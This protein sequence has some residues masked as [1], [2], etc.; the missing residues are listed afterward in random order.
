M[1][2]GS[3]IDWMFLQLWQQV[4]VSALGYQEKFHNLQFP[5]LPIAP[6]GA[7]II[8]RRESAPLIKRQLAQRSL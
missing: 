5:T 3:L 6:N 7:E 8:F 1:M 4:K 2:P